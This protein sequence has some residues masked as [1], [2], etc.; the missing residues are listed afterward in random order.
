MKRTKA[1]VILMC[2]Q[3]SK[4]NGTTERSFMD[5]Y[6]EG[7]RRRVVVIAASGNRDGGPSTARYPATFHTVMMVGA[8]DGQQVRP[9]YSC[10]G[11]EPGSRPAM[12]VVAPGGGDP[13][14]GVEDF[15]VSVEGVPFVGTSV[16]A[17]YAA[18]AV[19]RSI[20]DLDGPARS[21]RELQ[22]AFE[23]GC[24]PVPDWDELQHGKGLLQHLA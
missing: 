4:H 16:A 10:Y 17:A 20:G 9:D 6:L 19:A 11:L 13:T 2:L 7:A 12:F 18:G 3:L 15:A 23:A 14:P 5:E 1:D 22:R 21:S 8:V 24:R